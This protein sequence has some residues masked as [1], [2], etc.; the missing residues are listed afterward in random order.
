MGAA[1]VQDLLGGHRPDTRQGVELLEGRGVEVD[2][3]TRRVGRGRAGSGRDPTRLGG[4]AD[5]DLLAVDQD[6]R[7][8]ERAQVD[9]AA[10]AAR[11]ASARRRPGNRPAAW[12]RPGRR[13]FPATSTVTSPSALAGSRPWPPETAR[14]ATRRPAWPAVGWLETASDSPPV[15]EHDVRRGRHR[16]GHQRDHQQH[17]SRIQ[18]DPTAQ[19]VG[20]LVAH[21]AAQ[22]SGRC[23]AVE[24]RACRPAG[25]TVDGSGSAAAGSSS[26]SS[27]SRASRSSTRRSP[28][29][30]SSRP[31]SSSRRRAASA[32]S[33][34]DC[35]RMR[36][37]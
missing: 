3:R 36:R 5:Q 35:L 2:Q 25:A 20:D 24:T 31:S 21:P 15:R 7:Q 26:R 11:L 34:C 32:T 1:P 17:R 19:R 30:S 12:S 33:S 16:Q 6:P 29:W 28:A 13:T 27:P 37:R 18:P 8:V 23:R 22:P 4:P 10:R 14:A 9:P